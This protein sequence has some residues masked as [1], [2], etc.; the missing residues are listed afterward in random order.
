MSVKTSLETF[1]N[2]FNL[3]Y[4]PFGG[5]KLGMK[6]IVKS[7]PIEKNKQ[8]CPIKRYPLLPIIYYIL[9]YTTYHVT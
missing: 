4:Q 3:Y 2:I 5:S 8:M 9:Y 6:K 7:Q 1:E